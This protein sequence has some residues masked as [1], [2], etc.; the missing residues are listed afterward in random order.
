MG[1]NSHVAKD[2]LYL[3]SCGIHQTPPSPDHVKNMDLEKVYAASKFHSLEAIVCFALE[4]MP[5][6][7]SGELAQKWIQEKNRILHKTILFDAER[8]AICQELEKSEIWYCPLKGS[9]LKDFY[10]VP[11][12]RQMTDIDILFDESKAE[13]V[14]EFFIKRGYTVDSYGEHND[15]IYKKKPFYNFE[16]HRSLF[17]YN[18][19]SDWDSYW[20]HI[21]DRLLSDKNTKYGRR[22][23]DEDFYLYFMTHAYKHYI[24][25]GVGI[26]PLIDCWIWLHNKSDQMDWSIVHS[27]LEE[28]GLISFENTVRTL[29]ENLFTGIEYDKE[30]SPDLQDKLCYMLNSGTFGT[31][32]N[33]IY[34]HSGLKHQKIGFI[35]KIKFICYRAFPDKNWYRDNSMHWSAYQNPV[36]RVFFIA[37]R[38]LRAVFLKPGEIFSELKKISRL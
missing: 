5:G 9:I 31:L 25:S 14:R 3:V 6:G 8:K 26:R 15:D 35:A 18:V 1:V 17:C 10:P 4:S 19:Y 29:A 33:Q 12:M 37:K 20:S 11:A 21:T 36:S 28:I 27:H 32:E 24:G 30:L 7:F 22:M 16:M 38:L 13:E 34:R 2:L 23:T